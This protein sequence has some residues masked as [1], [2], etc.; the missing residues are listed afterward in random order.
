VTA[1][2]TFFWTQAP[3]EGKFLKGLAVLDDI[4]YFGITTWAERSVRDSPDSH[5]E[6][7]AFDLVNNKLLWRRVVSVTVFAFYSAL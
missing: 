5:G 4:A 7:A 6:L 2:T 1:F 3:G